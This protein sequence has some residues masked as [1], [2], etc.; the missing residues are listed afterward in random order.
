MELMPLIQRDGLSS[1]KA[2]TGVL[3]ALI[4]DI[5][6]FGAAYNWWSRRNEAA[7]TPSTTNAVLS[8]GIVPISLFAAYLGGSLIYKYGMGVGKGSG[9]KV[10][11]SQ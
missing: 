3:H 9:S 11:K 5:T 2:Q 7:F 1:K 8:A 4:N 6:V 10:K